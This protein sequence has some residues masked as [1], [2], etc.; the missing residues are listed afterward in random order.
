LTH[1]ATIL[2]FSYLPNSDIPPSE[3]AKKE[4]DSFTVK[5]P[6][7]SYD[8]PS[9]MLTITCATEGAAISYRI[10]DALDWTEY[11]K[12]PIRI[13]RN[14]TV[15]AKATLKDFN[16]SPEE[17]KEISDF[18]DVM[19]EPTI[20]FIEGE[21]MVEITGK[22]EDLK[23][24]YALGGA[25]P[26]MES[27]L[28]AG[29]FPLLVNDT[30]KAFAYI[31]DCDVAPSGMTTEIVTYYQTPRP[32]GHFDLPTRSVELSCDK[33]DATIYYR[34]GVNGEWKKYE[35]KF[36]VGRNCTVY[37]YATFPGYTDSEE[38]KLEVTGFPDSMPMPEITFA[39]DTVRISCDRKDAAIR[40]T[41]DGKE[42]TMGSTLYEGPFALTHNATILAFSYLPNSDIPPS[43]IA[44]KV[45]DTFTTA[46]PTG[47]YDPATATVTLS[48]DTEEAVIS[49][50]FNPNDDWTL[51][52]DPIIVKG[53]CTLYAKAIAEG[54]NESEILVMEIQEFKCT[55]VDIDYNGHFV[56]MSSADTAAKIRYTVDGTDP[57]A[58]NGIDYSEEFDA[59]GLCTVKAIAIREGYQNSEIKERKIEGYAD[60]YHAETAVGGVLASCFGW[61]DLESISEL[62]VEGILND[63]DYEFLTSMKALRYLDIEEV[64]RA[65]IPDN[66]FRNSGL[67]S[68]IMPSDL[69]QYGDS[70][71]SGCT[72]LC[73]II[74]NST[75]MDI[76][77]RLTQGL[78]NQNVLLYVPTE[79]NVADA[80]K[81]NIVVDDE[82]SSIILHDGCPFD[83]A[84][85]F[86]A[87]EISFTRNFTKKTVDGIC[88]GW[89][90]LTLPF[91]PEQIRNEK[92]GD[93]VSFSA[94]DGDYNGDKKPFWLYKSEENDW[95]LADRILPNVP[96]IISMPNDSNY[97]ED[98]RLGGNV[99][100]SAKDV[101]LIPD[102]INP[103]SCEWKHSALFV[104]TYMPVEGPT[105]RS[106]NV[107]EFDDHLPGSIFVENVKTLPFGAYITG[108]SRKSIPIF[109]DWNA[110]EM[111]TVANNGLEVETPAPGILRIT[112]DR[113]RRVDV[114]TVT[115]VVIRSLYF[116]GGE[117]VTIEGLTRDLY[118]VGQKKV[119]VK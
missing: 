98:F 4:V 80:D 89:E 21:G 110:M 34:I 94:W 40:Y 88:S 37:A 99:T 8:F 57:D 45:V 92:H 112:S 90:T 44:K 115:G 63:A 96:Y 35:Q 36:T 105:I 69:S 10:G 66:A 104:G 46:K 41:L 95:K 2:A 42:P 86:T 13:A 70:I 5:K 72:N 7:T 28:Y 60:E 117:T 106:L 109:G 108:T 47:T 52:T 114:M 25:A 73:G 118:I 18:P 93:L 14:C 51:Y 24:R 78:A 87:A 64:R 111:L 74:W 26:T 102:S 91:E 68:I 100:F 1:N 29:K 38:Y 55:P 116:M 53:N 67:V 50:R 23:F 79:I 82:A 9:R 62:R 61:K 65:N 97:V 119:M 76:E 75:I 12:E 3:I 30:I 11:T 84:R 17:K 20:S 85:E 43:E 6:E 39:N 19:P 59:E 16:D 15:Y 103:K 31:E 27:T 49:Y 107:E 71:L 58:D 33:N 81:L 77:S 56:I 54:Y 113:K 48:C 83:V 22:R 32:S 101:T